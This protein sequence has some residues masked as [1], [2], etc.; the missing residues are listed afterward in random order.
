MKNNTYY[1]YCNLCDFREITAGGVDEFGY[2]Y[3]DSELEVGQ[4]CPQC[5]EYKPE[6]GEKFEIGKLQFDDYEEEPDLED[7]D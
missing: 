4:D 2:F 5:K 6:P 3:C 7:Y 1:H